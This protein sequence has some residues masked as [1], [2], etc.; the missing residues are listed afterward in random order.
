MWHFLI[1]VPYLGKVS[2]MEN[3]GLSHFCSDENK[4]LQ[5]IAEICCSVYNHLLQT[6]CA[7]N[8]EAVFCTCT[9]VVCV[10]SRSREFMLIS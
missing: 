3:V 6:V 1:K 5:S 4:G 9:M 7:H 8:V 2:D 10:A